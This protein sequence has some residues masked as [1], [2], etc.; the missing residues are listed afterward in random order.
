[1]TRFARATHAQIRTSSRRRAP[2]V[3]L[4]MAT[5]AAMAACALGC[6]TRANGPR[7][8]DLGA[9]RAEPITP[10]AATSST[11]PAQA[12]PTPAGAASMDRYYLGVCGMCASQLGAK[13]EAVE[14]VHEG[15]DLRFCTDACSAA[16]ARDPVA[17]LARIDA[18]MIADQVAHYPLATSVVSGRPLGA[19]P[20]D[21]VWG[22]R[23]FRVA[24]EAER[25]TLL[26]DPARY[27]RALDRAVVEA[28]A[29]TYAM[30][31]KCP[32]QGDILPSDEVI[33]IV[34]ANRMVRVCCAR[35][36]RVV[37]ARPSQ[38]LSMVEY[39][40]REAARERDGAPR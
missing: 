21:V 7:E 37:R 22:N 17:G 28:Q 25:R 3:I 13:G 29:P 19:R 10:A 8:R 15:R 9:R 5:V 39:A 14:L 24:D 23:L 26:A 12:R 31:A 36:A 18:A 32:V 11:P 35:C 34:V 16:F 38:Y 2:R 1:M 4:A 6:A 33:D 20:V 30:A 27:L 40:N